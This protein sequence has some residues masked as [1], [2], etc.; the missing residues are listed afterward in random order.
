MKERMPIYNLFTQKAKFSRILN[1]NINITN[2][3]L[4][5]M[6]K[7]SPYSTTRGILQ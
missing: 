3:D 4:L 7:Y 1:W 6:D 2:T 5:Y